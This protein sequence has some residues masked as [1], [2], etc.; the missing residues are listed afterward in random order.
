MQKKQVL[1]IASEFPPNVGGIGNHAYNIAS[2]LSEADY[3]V[4]VMADLIDV[5]DEA[6]L[7]F[8]NN[9]NFTFHPVARSGFVFL[10][11]LKRI[12]KAIK[13][14]PKKDCIICSGKFSL[15]LI[16]LLKIFYP[17][18]KYIAVVHGTELDLKQKQAK[19]LTNYSL[20]KFDAVIAVSA[21]TADL[22]PRSIKNSGKVFIIHNGIN[23]EEFASQYLLQQKLKGS[24]S[25]ITV[26]SVSERKGQEN[27]IRALPFLLQKFPQ[28]QYHIVGKPYI[29]QQLEMLAG[30]L[31]VYEA[32]SFYGIVDRIALIELISKVDVKIML[33]NYTADGDFE[34][35]GIAVLEAAALGKPAIVSNTGGISEAIVDNKTGKVVDAKNADEITNALQDILDDYQEYSTN[36]KQWAKEHDWKILIKQYIKVIKAK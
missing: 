12:F 23:N 18:K 5:D 35:F 26:G 28:L 20:Q 3:D 24:P 25:L 29:Q 4:T 9:L 27:V 17:K 13:L 15:W 33:S 21:F 7:L 6:L 19:L 8:T 30:E 31:K 36:A 14:V 10:T 2:Y 32:V 1:F 16:V 11:Y 34:G 22:L